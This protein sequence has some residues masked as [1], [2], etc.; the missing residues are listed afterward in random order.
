M[1]LTLKAIQFPNHE[2]DNEVSPQL[3]QEDKLKKVDDN[4]DVIFE[5]I[6]LHDEEKMPDIQLEEE[7]SKLEKENDE[8]NISYHHE[9]EKKQK[10]KEKEYRD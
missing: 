4:K 10:I 1:L 6:R 9:E 2:P 7:P 5:S 3:P 8:I